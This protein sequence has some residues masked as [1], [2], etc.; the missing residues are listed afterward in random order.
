MLLAGDFLWTMLE[1]LYVV[2]LGC[3]WT[4]MQLQSIIRQETGIFD[5]ICVNGPVFPIFHVSS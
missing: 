4:G 1:R 2:M 5:N 3:Y